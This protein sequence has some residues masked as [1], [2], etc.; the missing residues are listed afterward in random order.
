MPADEL[1]SYFVERLSGRLGRTMVLKLLYLS[2]LE[3]RRYLGRPISSLTYV[4]HN[5]GPFDA[6]IYRALDRLAS[7]GEIEEEAVAYP[8]ATGYRYHCRAPGRIR[9]F[10]PADEAIL[11]FVLRSY[12]GKSLE[13]VLEVVYNTRPMK[14]VEGAPIGTPIPLQ[15]VN[16]EMRLALGGI[17][18]E[19]ALAAEDNVR[20]GKTVPWATLRRELLDRG[21]RTGS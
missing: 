17:D 7:A 11:S 21:R 20:E 10:S 9:H 8:S 6:E 2:D 14:E 16:D 13:S 1:V 18:L 15:S 4:L 5:H 12:I 19:S 3:A